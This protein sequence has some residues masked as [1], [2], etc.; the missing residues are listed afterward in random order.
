MVACSLWAKWRRTLRRLQMHT[1]GTKLFFLAGLEGGGG[2]LWTPIFL[3]VLSLGVN[4]AGHV[5]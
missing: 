1:D 2:G 3:R 4:I 5:G